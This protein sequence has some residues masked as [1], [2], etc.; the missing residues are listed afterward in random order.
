M[1]KVL[2]VD[3]D[4]DLLDIVKRILISKGF[5]V[6]TLLSGSNVS[7]VV[8]H[9][10]PDIILLDILLYGEAGTDICKEVKSQYH[11]P[12]LLFSG[13]TKKGEAF[14][15]SGADGFLSKPFD[16]NELVNIIDLHLSSSKKV[17]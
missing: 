2:I 6:H 13:D 3:N 15:D 12:I 7:N 11:I 10:N 1:R 14:A 17:E 5:D 16:I 9:Y 4:E 8:Q